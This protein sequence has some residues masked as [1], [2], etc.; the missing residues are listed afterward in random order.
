[1]RI[2]KINATKFRIGKPKDMHAIFDLL[3]FGYNSLP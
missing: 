1:M 3:L 2:E